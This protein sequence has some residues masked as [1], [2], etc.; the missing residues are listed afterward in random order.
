MRGELVG[1]PF[2]AAGERLKAAVLERAHVGA[3]I[4]EDML[5]KL[6]AETQKISND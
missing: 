2:A 4:C 1:E 5:S 3:D 6:D